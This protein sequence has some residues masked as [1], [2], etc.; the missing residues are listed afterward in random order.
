MS[1]RSKVWSWAL[2]DW[3]NSAFATVVMAGFFPIFFRQYWAAGRDGSE[4]TFLLGA[5]N[6]AAS[7]LI[8]VSAPLLGAIADQGF[9][10]KRFLGAFAILGIGASGTLFFIGEGQ[11]L[12]ALSCYA[13]AVVGFSGSMVFYDALLVNVAPESKWDRVSAFGYAL[14]YLGGGALFAF[15][16]LMTLKPHWFGLADAAE[17]IR[18]AFLMV[19]GWWML[20]SIP[21][22]LNI[23]EPVTAVDPRAGSR[24]LDG[25]RELAVTFAH[26][27]RYRHAFT[28]LLA[29]WLYIDGVDTIVRMAVD[30]GLALGI[31]A[32]DLISALLITQ[33]VGF[34]AAVAFG[35]LG[36]GFG[37]KRG[38]FLA[39]A[40]YLGVILWAYQM[41]SPWEFY[42]L[43][44]VIG[45]VQGGIQALS[46]SFYARLIPQHRATQF[47]GFYNMLGKFAAVVGPLLM[48]WTAV[49]TG[50]ARLSI[51]AVGALFIGGAIL[52]SL[53]DAQEGRRMAGVQSGPT[54][55]G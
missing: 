36:E 54:E 20:F 12:P 9:G 29:Y 32:N 3:A 16:V 10:K 28:F 27:R 44:A 46:R 1:E 41:Q 17:A 8:V 33:F 38:I 39:I 13:V 34:P 40:V 5:A 47:F 53:V 4:T 31:G 43:A 18:Y 24:V 42:V 11:W 7:L 6:S 30:Y 52:L 26:L 51:L 2:Y 48:G 19:A 14:G 37:P 55:G 49:L 50:D 21:L 23:K 15:N 25:F 22:F 35:R 45:L